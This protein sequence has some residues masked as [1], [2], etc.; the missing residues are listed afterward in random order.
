M[1]KMRQILIYTLLFSLFLSS[2]LAAAQK[3]SGTKNAAAAASVNKKAAIVVNAE[4]GK[5]LY[6]KNADKNLYPASLTKMM[7]LYL[8]FDALKK[9]Y[10]NLDDKI[11]I[12]KFAA[13]RAPSK[14]GVP[15]GQS[16]TL[17]TAIL[18]LLTKSA[19]DVATAVAEHFGKTE[20]NFAKMMTDVARKLGMSKTTFKNA[21]G[22]PNKGQTSTARDMAVL[23]MAL[24]NHFPQYYHLFSTN[25]F[26]FKNQKFVNHNKLL[27]AYDGTDGL[28]TGY[29]NASGFNIA[30][31]AKRNGHRVIAVV[32]GEKTASKRN[33]LAEKLMD[34]GF[35]KIAMDNKN[36]NPDKSKKSF[37]FRQ[38]AF[39]KEDIENEPET[40]NTIRNQGDE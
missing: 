8:V 27:K 1:A 18:A 6:A 36:L 9:N 32:F 35:L 31:S 11:K 20:A 17:E 39:E 22:L 25:E 23:S 12:S 7:T 38:A 37:S 5:V 4:T 30:A 29:T 3:K 24:M 19:N 16:I 15:A 14:L 40:F 26:N 34:E 10:A 21:S 2:P 13:S 33:D 28:K